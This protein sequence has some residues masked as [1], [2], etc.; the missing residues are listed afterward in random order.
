LC[1]R[2]STSHVVGL[3]RVEGGAEVGRKLR[4]RVRVVGPVRVADHRLWRLEAALDPVQ[5]GQEDR[6]GDQV[7]V[8]G[9]VA[10]AN[11]DPRARAALLRNA[12]ERRAVVVAPVRVGR[13]EAVRNDPLV[14]VHG[15]P[16]ER[17]QALRVLDHAGDEGG[18]ERAEPVWPCLVG[19]RVLAVAV[20]QREVEMEA[21][22]PLVRERPAHER[23]HEPLPRRD[24]LHRG[25][26]HERPVGGVERARVLHVDLV[27]RAHVLVAG[28][29][30]LQA[31]LVAPEEHPQHD[32]P[33]VGDGAHGVDARELVDVAAEPARSSRVALEEEELELGRDDRVEA[34]GGVHRHDL[35]EQVA[36]TDRPGLAAVE[37]PRLADAPR[38]LR[39]PGADPER[40]QV[41]SDRE[42]H[43][44]VFSSHDR[45][46]A[47][48]GAHH[49]RAEG[50]A[51]AGERGE[52][53]DWDV[54]APRDP[55][56]VGVQ[57]PDSAQTGRV[58]RHERRLGAPRVI[59]LLRLVLAVGHCALSGRA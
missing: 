58:E 59:V 18:R 51:V 16:E 3:E 6:R 40:G 43:V 48:V 11:L 54:L 44:P 15:R 35:P 12:A 47:Q 37:R 10:R 29:E 56:Q 39:L 33:R 8:R 20:V 32:V 14:R 25:L 23:R 53:T 45:R 41:G 50:H 9:A 17:L 46:V 31:E 13:R 36:R 26:Q 49:R 19:E 7:R 27:L 38:H 42:V 34:A 57:E 30:R 28:G 1:P 52:V 21:R 24:V 22:A 55:V 5:A 4:P 2:R